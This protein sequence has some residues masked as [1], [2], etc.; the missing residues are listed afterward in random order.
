MKECPECGENLADD[1][2][3]CGHCGERV[4]DQ[5][6]DKK[7]TMFGVGALSDE[8]L[9]AGSQG[10]GEGSEDFRLPSPGEMGVD[11]ESEEARGETES[12]S[13]EESGRPGLKS[14]SDEDQPGALAETEALPSLDEGDETARQQEGSDL[15]EGRI[16]SPGGGGEELG[17]S[18]ELSGESTPSDSEGSPFAGEDS[19]SPS[20][21][22]E[23]REPKTPEIGA[24]STEPSSP[25]P[26]SAGSVESDADE[27][28]QMAET[29]DIISEPGDEPDPTP[30]SSGG[31]RATEEGPASEPKRPNE[32]PESASK[33]GA[34]SP[35]RQGDDPSEPGTGRAGD[36]VDQ[37]SASR[38]PTSEDERFGGGQPE[39]EQPEVP[40]GSGGPPEP[41]RAA[42]GAQGRELAGEQQPRSSADSGS[43]NK[44]LFVIVGILAAMFF[45]CA[46][47]G[48]V[49]YFVGFPV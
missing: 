37:Q 25:E 31:A 19:Q 26:Q 20:G 28:R 40:A 11:G 48:A 6:E 21:V 36:Q 34:G 18:P 33:P 14:G 44:T 23:Q 1:A 17:A 24:S 38:D 39:P 30:R 47:G 7:Q 27:G 9:E 45:V 46:A 4:E 29:A 49:L 3:H 13:G 8:D 12:S 42:G 10:D 5:E 2:V 32:R 41:Q 35:Q 43:D 15:Q 22:E 16:S